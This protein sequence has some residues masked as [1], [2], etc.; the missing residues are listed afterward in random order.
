MESGI[1]RWI[2]TSED[3]RKLA[4]PASFSFLGGNP[5]SQIKL[6]VCCHQA[7]QRVPAHPL[8]HPVQVGAALAQD[9]FPGFAHDDAGENISQKNRSYCELTAHYWA[10]K[11][12]E[13]DYYGFFHYRRYLYL[14]EH[15]RRPYRLAGELTAEGLE[16]LGFDRLEQW[17][18]GKACVVPMGEDMHISVRDHYARAPYHHREDLALV[19]NIVR[20]KY[21]DYVPAMEEYLSGTNCY[22]GNIFIMQKPLFDQYCGWLFSILEEFDRRADTTGYSTQEL[23]VDGYLAERLLGV[24]VTHL[25]RTT[26]TQ[27]Y[28]LPRVQFEPDS[29]KRVQRTL[30][31]ALLPPGSR[32]RAWVKK[33]R[34]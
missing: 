30:L 1:I 17:L 10:W 11:N 19:E 20:E 29:K 26:A 22:F 32:R 27:V 8:L 2:N 4:H 6:F 12:V 25:R 9:H 24:Y 21:P 15:A 28:E 31:N 18:E 13:A 34:G 23:R 5:L 16:T 3:K 7:G 14:D 33:G